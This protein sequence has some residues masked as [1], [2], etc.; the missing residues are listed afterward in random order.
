MSERMLFCLGDGK[1]ESKGEGYQKNNRVFNKDVSEK[2][3][4]EI[5]SSLPNINISFLWWVDEKD[6]TDDEKEYN[7]IYKEIGGFL[8]RISYEEAWQNWWNSASKE[9]KEKITSIK[10]FDKDIFEGIT[11]IKVEGD[12]LKGQEVEV[13]VAGKTYRAVTN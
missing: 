5:K 9:D 11:G 12:N 2:E 13:K 10:Y 7:S 6:M 1:C 3:F 8:K 4:D